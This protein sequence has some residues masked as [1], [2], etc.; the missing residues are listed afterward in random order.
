VSRSNKQSILATLAIV[1]TISVP[2]TRTAPR[3]EAVAF[4][5]ASAGARTSTLRHAYLKTPLRFERRAG[6]SGD[7]I[8]RGIGY[9]VSLSNGDAAVT[10]GRSGERS[11]TITIRLAGRRGSVGASTEGELPGRSNQLIGNDARQWRTGV[12]A[13]ARIAYHDVYPGIDLV[14]YGTQQQLEYDFVLRPGASPADIAFDIAGARS[15]KRG[16]EG[17]LIIQTETGSLTHRAPVAYQDVRGLRTPVDA[18]YTIRTDGNVAFRIG[19]YDPTLPLVIDPV[20]TYATYLG[21]SLE[22]RI[23]GVAIDASGNVIVAGETYSANAPTA[24]PAQPQTHGMGDAFVAKLTPSGDALV[25]AT[26]FGGSSND[27]AAGVDLDPSGAAYIAGSTSSW[28]FPTLNAYQ[29]SYRGQFDTFVVKLDGNGA[30]VY[31]TLLGGGFEDYA[32][33]IAVDGLGRAHLTGSTMSADFPTV[34]PLQASAGGSPVFRTTNGGDT[35]AGVGNGLRASGV[36]SFAIDPASPDTI[37]AGSWLEGVFRSTDG[38]TTWV[39]SGLEFGGEVAGVAVGD[40]VPGTVYAAT[41]SGIH[42]SR[43]GGQSWTQV[44]QGWGTAIVASPQSPST[45]YAGLSTNGF[46]FGVFKSIDGGDTWT[47]T[48]LVDGAVALAVSG[49]TVYA[50]TNNAVYSS[51]GGGNWSL[52][53]GGLTSRATA[54]VASA[55]SPLVAYAATFDGLFKTVDGG[56]SWSA[57]PLLAGLPIAALAIGT[58]DPST[59]MASVQYGGTVISNDAGENWRVTHSQNAVFYAVAIHPAVATTAYLGGV[60][61]RDAFVATIGAGGNTLEFSTYFGGSGTE[62]GTDIALDADG[63]RYVVG[64]TMSSDLPL[65]NA[66]QTSF[67]DLQDAFALRI[68]PEGL[69]YATYLG[70]NGFESETRVAVDLSGRAHIAGLTWSMNYPVVNAWQPEPGGGFS[71]VF[72]S[73]LEPSGTFVYSTYLG[74]NGQETDWS[75]THGPD[76]AATSAGDTYLTGTTQSLNFPVS[77]GAFQPTHGGGQSDAFVTRLDA[78]GQ[79]QFSSYLGGSGDDAGRSIALDVN[80][81][82]AVAGTTNSTDFPTRNAFQ[83]I[84]A[85]S[86][87]GFIARISNDSGTSDTVAPVTTVAVTGT[88]GFNGWYRSVVAVILTATDGESG[89]GVAAIRYRLN[90]GALQTYTGPFL[91]A[92]EGT[93]SVTAESVDVAGNVEVPAAATV[94]RI[95]TAGP[96]VGIA[97]PQAREYLQSRTIDVSISA[98]DPVSG[99]AG[100]ATVTLDGAPFAG[101][102]IDL[103]TLTLG[104]HVL[105]A[106]ASDVAGNASQANVTFQVVD[107]LDTII[108]VPA[109][110]ATIQAAIDL[111]VDGDTV[112]VAP[113]TYH[114]VLNFRGKAITVVSDAGPDQTIIDGDGAGSVV[115]F[116][117]GE[118]RAAVL[119]GFTIRGGRSINSGGGIYIAS[120]SPTV[121]GNVITGNRSCTGV[122]IYSSFGS[123]MIQANRITGNVID[124]CT[125]G[126]GIGVYIGGNS[127]AEILDN[128]ITDNTGAAA[129]GG[130][131]A[132]F[133]AGSAVVRNNV[134]AR[135]ITSGPAGCGF[136]GG[137]ASANFSQAKIV[138][139]LIV[140]NSA[141]T[142]GGVYWLGSTGSNLFVNN[143]IADNGASSMPGM[144]VSGFDARNE[145]HN[146]IIAARTGPALYCQNG[147]TVSSPTL[148]SNDIF[149]AQGAAYAGTCADQT[150]VNGNISADPAFLGPANR[151]YRVAMTSPAVD[152][153]NDAAPFLPLLDLA[154]F[155]RV[156]DGDADGVARV[157]MG[158][159]ESRNRVPAV[160]AGADQ[161]I[162]AGANCLGQV[163][164]SAVASDPDGDP[165]TL[166]WSGVFGTASGPNLSVTLPVGTHAITVTADDGIGGRASDTV[167]VTVADTTP[168][169]I[170]GVKASPSVI[171]KSN[172][173]M[174]PVQI[175]VDATDGCGA[176]DC[177]IVSVASNEPATGDWEITGAL[178][179]NLRAE[180]LGKGDGRIYTITIECTDAAGNVA[181]STV[182]VAVPK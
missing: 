15:V 70:G 113:G 103:S 35:W 140:G 175:F 16:D 122:G 20:L 114:E 61:N 104:T 52:A 156:F 164:L 110:A 71:D 137:L 129:S 80:G 112:R 76:V 47:D 125:G 49:S 48:G 172:H 105:S 12:P 57:V 126:W 60:V 182:T 68:G 141:C 90:G 24:N 138:G 8:G 133:S 59:L 4:Q 40:G 25:Y 94:I 44:L 39:A 6:A 42:R 67:G 78:T 89:S 11:E 86:D 145:L 93:S 53:N 19:S 180:R 58:S 28:D 166:T 10:L 171:D 34:N 132:L 163:V 149:S 118:T 176:V 55:S 26:Y 130:G 95:D 91:I 119:S 96:T 157:D 179:L 121:R 158:A 162:A 73:V 131:L 142:G 167:V 21:G 101:S 152:T 153:G 100:P 120:S 31:S 30:L 92:A 7:F 13:Y 45:I 74:G 170:A 178:T 134:I 135:N 82:V 108:N 127:A 165:V 109:E 139:N 155:A 148:K 79:L 151:D 36:R 75:N 43:D 106:S 83:P 160:N 174:V 23:H 18:A 32:T 99:V 107:V 84:P 136:G 147:A 41:Q 9:A 146:N 98:S 3:D 14:Y 81:E 17:D 29:A 51:V 66:V 123:P 173:M 85:G 69:T 5:R 87:E 177:R 181:T 115:S 169:V 1:A 102:V 46:P 88:A 54:L 27:A 63:G 62:R 111:A 159:L 56:A 77:A 72:V 150:G 144:Y 154:G 65:V 124:G 22:E 128:E 116:R 38:G 2:V 64:E 37:Y 161:T 97:S 33:A 168:P 50:A 117:S 143:T